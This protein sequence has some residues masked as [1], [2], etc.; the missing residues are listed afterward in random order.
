MLYVS[1]IKGLDSFTQQGGF[2]FVSRI[3]ETFEV[4]YL[5]PSTSFPLTLKGLTGTNGSTKQS[6]RI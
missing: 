2:E 3:H 4:K 1:F 5:F 6:V